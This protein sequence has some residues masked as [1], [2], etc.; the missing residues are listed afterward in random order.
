M[1]KLLLLCVTAAL[2][3]GC[4]AQKMTRQ[5]T[6]EMRNTQIAATTRIYENVTKEDVLVAADTIFRLADDSDFEI[7]HGENEVTGTHRWLV[8]FVIGLAYGVENWVVNAEQINGSVKVSVRVSTLAH[9]VE[10]PVQGAA[11]YAIFFNR[12]DYL[13][14]KSGAWW[15]CDTAKQKIEQLNLTG[16]IRA[17]CSPFIDDDAPESLSLSQ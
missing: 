4:A 14:G 2:V 6:L 3:S 12:M 15:D 16:S 11:I 13:L 7:A 17:L 5:E 1:Q 9:D 8:Y 10:T